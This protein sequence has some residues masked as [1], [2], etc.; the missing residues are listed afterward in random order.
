MAERIDSTMLLTSLNVPVVIVHGDADALVP[1]DRA[2]EA[3]ALLQNAYYVEIP[4]VG[5]MPMKEAP[6]KTAEALRH[7]A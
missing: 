3:N 4:G 6:E 5:H 1:I 2:R 7:L